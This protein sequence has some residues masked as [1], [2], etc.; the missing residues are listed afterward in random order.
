[1]QK[2]CIYLYCILIPEIICIQSQKMCVCWGF[3]LA[4]SQWSVLTIIEQSY[5]TTHMPLLFVYMLLELTV[6]SRNK[7]T[8]IENEKKKQ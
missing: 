1:M 6:E 5:S 8:K 7:Q 4:F 2:H 3:L